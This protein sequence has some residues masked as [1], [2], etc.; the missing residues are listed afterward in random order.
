[1]SFD[2][3]YLVIYGLVHPATFPL[4]EQE[5]R[6]ASR[7]LVARILEDGSVAVKPDG[8]GDELVVPHDGTT[9]ASRPGQL[10]LVYQLCICH[11]EADA[12]RKL[13]ELA[14]PT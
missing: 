4:E 9:V 1:M 14:V 3:L 5:T 2:R 10:R 8:N 12:K 7:G 13:D 11:S 6:I